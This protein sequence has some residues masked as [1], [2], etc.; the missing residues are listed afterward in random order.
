MIFNK[1]L[2][3]NNINLYYPLLVTLPN[4]YKVKVTEISNIVFSPTLT[5]DRVLFVHTF[6]LNLIYVHLLAS[7]LKGM[8]SFNSSL[9]LIQGSSLKRPLDIGKAKHGLCFQCS[10]CH[11]CCQASVDD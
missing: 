9:C 4:R 2:L 5:V 1:N 8:V 3:T 11:I 6:K 10:K 7:Y